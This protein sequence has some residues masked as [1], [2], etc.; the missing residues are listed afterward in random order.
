MKVLVT[1]GAGFIGSHIVERLLGEGEEIVVVDNFD[2]YYDIRLK[3]KNVKMFKGNPNFTFVKGDILDRE[4]MHPIIKEVDAVIHM[5][6]QAGVRASIENPRKTFEVN[7][8]GT[9]QLLELCLNSDVKKFI[10]AS[11]SS[12]Y[13]KVK[14]LPIDEEHPKEPISPYGVSKLSAEH[15]CRVFYEVYGLKTV[16]LRY[17]TVYG[18][19]MSCLLYTSDAADE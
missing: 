13:G 6:A 1:G 8:Y 9:F 7:A 19:R 10:N 4:L 15:Y 12:V 2:P 14:Y 3:E 5:A 11:S 18:P 16:N 17:F